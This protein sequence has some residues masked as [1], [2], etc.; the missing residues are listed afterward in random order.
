LEEEK[1]LDTTGRNAGQDN[2]YFCCPTRRVI[3][4]PLIGEGREK[5]TTSMILQC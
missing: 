5:S 2:E 4:F 1:K 3:A